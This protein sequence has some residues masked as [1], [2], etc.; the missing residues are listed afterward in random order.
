MRAQPHLHEV[1]SL[2]A[3]Q[4]GRPLVSEGHVVGAIGIS[5]DTPAHDDEIA[6]A[7]Q[8]VLGQ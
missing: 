7:A 6:R 3:S 5:A 1:R 2:I 4:R 8:G